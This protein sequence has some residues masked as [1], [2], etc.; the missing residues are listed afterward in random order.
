MAEEVTK[1]MLNPSSVELVFPLQT[2]VTIEISKIQ[3]YIAQLS[4]LFAFYKKQLQ[5]NG[6]EIKNYDLSSEIGPLMTFLVQLDIAIKSSNIAKPIITSDPNKT[7]VFDY[8]FLT[9]RIIP[10]PVDNSASSTGIQLN[11]PQMFEER[12]Y[13]DG[14]K[15]QTLIY[16]KIDYLFLE[17]KTTPRTMAVLSTLQFP[18]LTVSPSTLALVFNSKEI[19]KQINAPIP[20][21]LLL[22]QGRQTT[23]SKLEDGFSF[24]GFDVGGVTSKVL[25]KDFLNAYIQPIQEVVAAPKPPIPKACT[26]EV[27]DRLSVVRASL[28]M[29]EIQIAFAGGINSIELDTKKKYEEDKQEFIELTKLCPDLISE[30]SLF[31]SIKDIDKLGKLFTDFLEKYNLACI[32][33]EAIKCVMPQIPCDQILRDLTV[34]NFEQRLQ[35]AFPHQKNII[36]A[37]TL[38]INEALEK[39]NKR[40]ADAGEQPLE[41]AAQTQIVLDN[42]NKVI[43]L[44][45]LCKIDIEAI[46]ELIKNL[47]NIKLPSFNLFDWQFN[48]KI[49]LNL[50]IIEALLKMLLSMIEQVL[51]ELVGCDA[52]DGLI[53]GIINS[54]VD[55]PTGLYGDVAAMFGGDFDFSNFQGTAANGIQNFLTQSGDQLSKIL[56][57][58][59]KL[60]NNLLGSFGVSGTLGFGKNADNIL[61]GN[62]GTELN[63][64]GGLVRASTHTIGG[65]GI[66]G[67]QISPT[68]FTGIIDV[69][70]LAST[71]KQADFLKEI[72]QFQLTT[73]GT[74][75]NAVRISDDSLVQLLSSSNN[76]E[77]ARTVP[78]TREQQLEQD[79]YTPL[80]TRNKN[81]HIL[82]ALVNINQTENVA[83][84]VVPQASLADQLKEYVKTCFALLSPSEVIDLITAN[85]S[86]EVKLT[87][88]EIARIRF[89][90][91][92]AILKYP[93][94][95]ALLFASF[96]KLTKLDSIGPRLQI[97]SS[98]P[99]VKE[100]MVDPN[101]CAPFSNLRDFRENLMT[102][103]LSQE[104]ANRLMDD[105][106]EDDRNRANKLLNNLAKKPPIADL[107]TNPSALAPNKTP[108]GKQIEEIDRAI[109]NTLSNL[110]DQIKLSFDKE[111]EAYPNA[112]AATIEV[113]EKITKY[114]DV[115][116]KEVTGFTKPD[117]VTGNDRPINQEYTNI[118]N[119]TN[120]E[121]VKDSNGNY[122]TIN[123]ERGNYYFTRKIHK[124]KHGQLIYSVFGG[125]K[126]KFNINNIIFDI[127]SSGILPLE[128]DQTL[129]SIKQEGSLSS[130]S[131]EFVP[132]WNLKYVE[133]TGSYLFDIRTAGQIPVTSGNTI[134]YAEKLKF[135][136]SI[137]DENPLIIEEI[138]LTGLSNELQNISRNNIFYKLL[139]PAFKN[140]APVLKKANGSRLDTIS[141]DEGLSEYI[142]E[143][144]QSFLNRN[145]L[146]APYDAPLLQN[147]KALQMLDDIKNILLSLVDFTPLPTEQEKACGIDTHLLQLEAVKK[148]V[149][150]EFNSSVPDNL[151]SKN[152]QI[153]T[154]YS[155]SKPGHLSEKIMTGLAETL[156]R[157]S[158]IHN[159]FKGLFL[160][161]KYNYRF[162]VFSV[163]EI[164][165]IFF[166][167]TVKND[168]KNAKLE[169]DFQKEIEKI[170]NLY[171][172]D[173]KHLIPEDDTGSN[174][175]RSIVKYH[176]DS[177]LKILKT[178]VQSYKNPQSINAPNTTPDSSTQI[179][180]APA[181]LQQKFDLFTQGFGLGSS[182]LNNNANSDLQM[183]T[184]ISLV[185]TTSPGIAD[186]IT[187]MYNETLG[188]PINNDIIATKNRN[189]FLQSLARA[190]PYSNFYEKYNYF[191]PPEDMPPPSDS[192]NDEVSEPLHSTVPT[193]GD[194]YNLYK[195]ESTFAKFTSNLSH[196]IYNSN[197]PTGYQFILERYVKFDF[198]SPSTIDEPQ[199]FKDTK[200]FFSEHLQL[201]GVVNLKNFEEIMFV[202]LYIITNSTHRTTL[203]KKNATNYE[204]NGFWFNSPPKFGYRIC[205]VKDYAGVG[206]LSKI[207]NGFYNGMV[208]GMQNP[209]TFYFADD[210]TSTN[211]GEDYTTL[212][213][214][215]RF[216]TG[217]IQTYTSQN[218]DDSVSRDMAA[219]HRQ[220]PDALI[221]KNVRKNLV[222]PVI[223]KE[224][225]F[226]E[227][228]YNFDNTNLP[229]NFYNNY[230]AAFLPHLQEAVERK[231]LADPTYDILVNLC[232]IEGMSK[233]FSLINSMVGMA[234]EPMFKLLDGTKELIRKNYEIQKNS[235]NFKSRDNRGAYEKQK[236]ASQEAPP[237]VDFLK[238]SATIPINML[239]GLATAVDPN[240]FLA[241][242]IVLAGKT[243]FVQPKFR[244]VEAGEV[245][246]IE[247]S[248]QTKTITSDEAGVAYDGY[249][250][251]LETGE[252]EIKINPAGQGNPY[253]EFTVMAQ[254][255]PQ[256]NKV[257]KVNGKVVTKQ[258]TNVSGVPYDLRTKAYVDSSFNDEDEVDSFDIRNSTPIFPG[259]K[260]NIPYSVASLLLAPFPIFGPSS[261]TTYNVAMPFGPLFLALEPLIFETP[262]FKASIPKK[263]KQIAKDENGNTIC[264]DKKEG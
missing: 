28:N 98:D 5:L 237:A 218:I 55:A 199:I 176:I 205:L 257:K 33:D 197:N 234:S 88:T 34:D 170:Y 169:N 129:S 159:I 12:E 40:R 10:T 157:T 80:K 113:E 224:I 182:F 164:I 94:R 134:K 214:H 123:G 238:A 15:R 7:S 248:N 71:E 133:T 95:H 8:E 44:E 179:Q 192:E 54:N 246:K 20:S 122:R 181:Q 125:I 36:H 158:V 102:Q 89:P 17:N 229:P 132:R 37:I 148:R 127:N 220:Q 212:D 143:I 156:I 171:K 65:V 38:N 46:V 211:T 22:C 51:N 57:F 223:E 254:V 250:N 53:A 240:I 249:Y 61:A 208:I 189:I 116:P 83:Q 210:S 215:K 198:K 177:V 233:T 221:L 140:M 110:F 16:N 201:N 26:P 178:I 68:S 100:K 152:S 58:E 60:G 144:Y 63:T 242:K 138:R 239:K 130:G 245:V 74:T 62:V 27:R 149:I 59:S 187:R 202:I 117:D 209:A 35:T 64:F 235:G 73:D 184:M 258:G 131:Y 119:I 251:Y 2:E 160:F 81:R 77:I 136:G 163:P 66:A 29:A 112:S 167:H 78:A 48:F 69:N 30:I 103:V 219:A 75:T 150:K 128:I 228:L 96:G 137:S 43:D 118:K 252:M 185:A 166:E 193:T 183:Q 109:A 56:V 222:V 108:D 104:L 41:P 97:L 70:T 213:N 154:R 21:S 52:L 190:E 186:A 31:E 263:E 90:L 139:N 188:I 255:D 206:N 67:F 227:E 111:I 82:K 47:F 6:N 87:I 13:S 162:D 45:A 203:Y 105:L 76:I 261:L 259:E 114:T 106:V 200:K 121:G 146:D 49:D 84:L 175:L 247:G 135:T 174:K 226:P 260:I 225:E 147:S 124:R 85:P 1:S 191:T 165:Y 195:P 172:K 232:L 253:T 126:N 231:M 243:G 264:D 4:K 107:M 99:T 115:K 79:V 32:V 3:E 24:L 244:R 180:L 173:E 141:Y 151:V 14:S 155:D 101:I 161:D 23:L 217:L 207:D 18:A 142:L 39:E 19:L 204:T 196:H 168:I 145:L 241:D 91:L 262:E 230:I 256:T 86:L 11:G 93:E 236:K 9:L 25:L 120:T 216:K 194:I 92:N 50:A 42:I 153:N 72:G